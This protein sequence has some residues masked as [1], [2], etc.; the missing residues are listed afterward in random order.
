MMGQWRVLACALVWLAWSAA[1]ARAAPGQSVRFE[2]VAPVERR[3]VDLQR[4]WR[5]RLRSLEATVSARR[6]RT[7]KIVA[8][9]RGTRVHVPAVARALVRPGTL[10]LRWV[11][12]E[13]ETTRAWMRTFGVA[14]APRHPETRVFAEANGWRD[15]NT[16][17]LHLEYALLGPSP[18]AIARAL[19]AWP[20]AY[21]IPT[22]LDLWFG[23]V[24]DPGLVRTYLVARTPF[25]TDKEVRH[26]ALDDD[27]RAQEHDVWI[28]FAP[29]GAERLATETAA[30]VGDKLA[31]VIDGSI[32]FAPVIDSPLTRGHFS[33]LTTGDD[34]AS[35]EADGRSLAAAL[36]GG[37]LPPG[38]EARAAGLCH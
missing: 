19:A 37:P 35:R 3:V 4:V 38:L 9:V 16:G 11:T 14:Y 36:L 6:E 22:D 18:E 1:I 5:R 32:R 12:S 15:H 26:A 10:E 28:E 25:L 29:S 17:E 21:P 34:E 33:V 27:R 23:P 13:N 2:V 20:T 30:R 7:G 31:V 8:C 24:A